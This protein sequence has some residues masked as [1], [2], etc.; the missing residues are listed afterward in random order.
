M[1]ALM[2]GEIPGSRSARWRRGAGQTSRG[3]RNIAR[4]PARGVRRTVPA[5]AAAA[6]CAAAVAVGA[7]MHGPGVPAPA[8]PPVAQVNH[9]V[10]GAA[11]T[12]RGP[13]IDFG[14]PFDAVRIHAQWG[15]TIVGT[16][17]PQ[18]MAEGHDIVVSLPTGT[19]AQ[20]LT[21]Y[22]AIARGDNDA[23]FSAQLQSLAALKRRTWLILEG[24]ADIDAGRC[25]TA[26]GSAP[27]GTEFVAA[28]RHLHSMAGL[29]PNVQWVWS[30][31]AAAFSAANTA[32]QYF[33]G[34]EYVDWV[35][36]RLTPYPG[37]G[38]RWTPL[39]DLMTPVMDWARAHSPG[40]PVMVSNWA[41]AESSGPERPE[42]LH[43]AAQQ[44][45]DPRWSALQAMIWEDPVADGTY[46]GAC[47]FTMSDRASLDAFREMAAA[48][49]SR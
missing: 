10:W 32:I 14:Q 27:C 40:K 20:G 6:V 16:H 48:L 46:S 25:A 34:P 35:G 13:E 49:R 17:V 23:W 8:G 3:G 42:W 19:V 31:T 33:P 39:V 21:T 18:L 38:N 37:C 24:G 1:A 43:A 4:R 9:G 26:A 2:E 45:R 29:A 5:M 7:L 11:D 41:I 12:S 47:H 36:V 28:W 22:A 44:L 15:G 30:P